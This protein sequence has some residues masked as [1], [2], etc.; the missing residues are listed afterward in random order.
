VLL[1]GAVQALLD[2]TGETLASIDRVEFT[3]Q[4]DRVRSRLTPSAFDTV[5]SAGSVLSIDQAV[6]FAA[7]EPGMEDPALPVGA[8]RAKTEK[9]SGLTA[10]ERQVAGLVAQGKANREIAE[11]LVV[12]LKTVET[13]ITH[14]LNKLG[15]D[16]RVQ[17]ATWAVNHG[18]A[19]PMNPDV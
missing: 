9:Y 7:A 19:R 10:R 18:L 8:P 12:E 15:F 16:N 3:A 1:F 11:T 4:L 6:A 2:D 5:R 13:H 14:I 17:I